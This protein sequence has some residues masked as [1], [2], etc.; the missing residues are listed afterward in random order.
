MSLLFLSRDIITAVTCQISGDI[1]DLIPNRHFRRDCR[2]FRHTIHETCSLPR[3]TVR[4]AIALPDPHFDSIDL[5]CAKHD[6]EWEDG[7]V[8]RTAMPTFLVVRYS[9]SFLIS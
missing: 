4:P 9:I 2:S 5:H 7:L 3:S 6:V 1:L 8:C